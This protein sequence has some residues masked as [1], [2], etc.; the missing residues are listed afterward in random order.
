MIQKTLMRRVVLLALLTPVLVYA[1]SAQQ[2]FVAHLNGEQAIPGNFSQAKA[3]C[4]I[5]LDAAETEI[6][7]NCSYS[8]ISATGIYLHGNGM[9]G[10]KAPVLF[11][12]GRVS[13]RSGSTRPI[14]FPLTPAQVASMRSH[15]MYVSMPSSFNPEGEI[16]GQIKQVHTVADND[17][18]GTSDL[19]VFR[20][21]TSEFW[22]FHTSTRKVGRTIYGNAFGDTFFNDTGDFDGD[23]RFDP[24]L[25]TIVDNQIVWRI[26][27]TEVYA[28]KTMTLGSVPT[29]SLAIAD[30]DGDGRLDIAVFRRPTAEWRILESSSG[31]SR[32]E[33]WGTADDYPAVG[34]YDGDGRADLAT[35]RAEGANFVW[36]IR[37][38]STGRVRRELFGS[39]SSDGFQFF[40]PFDWDG[41]GRQDIRVSRNT[42]PRENSIL[43]SSD[44]RVEVV[45][46]GLPTDSHFYGDYDGDGKTDLVARSKNR[47]YYLWQI[48]RSSDAKIDYA[49]WGIAPFEGVGA[50]RP[51]GSS[52]GFQ[53]GSEE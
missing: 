53:A 35:V 17:G 45:K 43:K 24:L 38:S 9:V 10:R 32:I 23:G 2:R 19:T 1:T 4:K 36:N 15:L 21:S 27:G 51:E 29:D 25:I 42:T 30:Y 16:R 7:V 28:G 6:A 26:Y 13:G 18:D 3:H 47:G 40:S 37:N 41:D 33:R 46:F 49:T 48:R 8:N 5:V 14:T 50:D 34:D 52:P 44:G 31:R 22:S 39:S 11:N 20:P 12:L